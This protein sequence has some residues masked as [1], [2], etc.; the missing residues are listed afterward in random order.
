[1]AQ[2]IEQRAE[3]EEGYVTVNGARL[4]YCRAGAGRPL[5]LLHG[6][7]GSVKNWRRNIRFLAQHANVYAVDL[8]NMG[9]VGSRARA[10]L[11]S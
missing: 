6:L 1:M 2:G 11:K 9:G 5:L 7:V 10:G 8:L 4:H 3:I